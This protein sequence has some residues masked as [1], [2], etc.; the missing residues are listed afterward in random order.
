MSITENDL[1][2]ALSAWGDGIVSISAA[3][4]RK[5]Y[6]D[7]RKVAK[8]LIGDLYGY[9]TGSVL[10]KPTLSGG[11]HTFRTSEDGALSYFVGGNSDY[12]HDSGFAI[13]GWRKVFSDAKAVFLDE[14][15]ALWM[16]W[17]TLVDGDGQ[18]TKV[19][20]S[21]GYKLC[22]QGNLKIVL[23]HSSLPYLNQI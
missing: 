22:E 2:N 6:E 16:G 11:D 4:E 9:S 3:Y 10:F 15:I 18:S 19:D 20:K 23:H 7:A 12:P 1:A 14:N 17:V 13:K 5:G 21:F 8:K